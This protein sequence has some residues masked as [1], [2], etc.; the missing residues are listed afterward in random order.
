V[1]GQCLGPARPGAPFFVVLPSTPNRQPLLGV[2]PLSCLL[3]L[4][5]P[6]GFYRAALCTFWFD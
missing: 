2:Q 3:C 6:I 5:L 4:H 1:L